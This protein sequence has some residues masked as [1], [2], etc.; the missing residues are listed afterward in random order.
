MKLNIITPFY[1]V[2]RWIDKHIEMLKKQTESHFTCVLV[3]D[4]ST[5]NSYDVCCSLIKGDDRFIL[6]RNEEKK[7]ALRNFVESIKMLNLDDEDVIITVDGDDWLYDENVLKKVKNVYEQKKVLMTY[8]NYMNYP[9]RTLGHC[10]SYPLNVIE[11]NNYRGY[12]WLA[13]QLRTFKFKLWKNIRE[14]DF[15]D[16]EGHFLQVTYDLA[17]MYPMLEMSGGNFHCFRE[18]LY[19]YN[20][21]NELNDYKIKG[22]MQRQYDIIIRNREKYGRIF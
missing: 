9:S 12:A 20:R 10:D 18:P 8:G 19:V 5:D 22:G 21:E 15:L 7:Y 14:E 2:D 1:N 6:I 4:L 3:D 16:N 17:M 11:K 13:S